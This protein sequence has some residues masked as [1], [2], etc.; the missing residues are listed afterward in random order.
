MIVIRKPAPDDS[1]YRRLASRLRD[2]IDQGEYGPGERLPSE[3]RL[4]QIYDVGRDTVRDALT[5]LRNEGRVVTTRG[6]GTRVRAEGEMQ[7]ST[8][9]AGAYIGSRMPTPEEQEQWGLPPGVPVFVVEPP[10]GDPLIVPADRVR[11]HVPLNLHPD[12]A[13]TAN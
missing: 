5:L 4:E 10:G 2:A 6:S 7:I 8:L 13:D 11:L 9:P 12:D 3:K 1:L